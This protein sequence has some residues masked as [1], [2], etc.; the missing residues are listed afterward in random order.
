MAI[1]VFLFIRFRLYQVFLPIFSSKCQQCNNDSHSFFV[2]L[3]IRDSYS[4]IFLFSLFI[5]FLFFSFFFPSLL[6]LCG[7]NVGRHLPLQLVMSWARVANFSNVRG[8]KYLEGSKEDPRSCN[9]E[10]EWLNLLIPNK[11]NILISTTWLTFPL[12]SIC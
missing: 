4:G 6:S 1:V 5:R 7:S 10:S 2:S 12:L 9:L 8:H 11:H 3:F